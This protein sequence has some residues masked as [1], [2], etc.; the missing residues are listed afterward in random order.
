M[1]G[2]CAVGAGLMWFQF[3]RAWQE[4]QALPVVP[5]RSVRAGPRRVLPAVFQL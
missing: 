2:A 5:V 1:A 3:G 4:H